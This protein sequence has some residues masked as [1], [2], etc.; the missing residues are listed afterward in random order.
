MRKIILSLAALALLGACAAT[1]VLPRKDAGVATHQAALTTDP[2]QAALW[3]EAADSGALAGI[4]KLRAGR[5]QLAPRQAARVSDRPAAMARTPYP[6]ALQTAVSISLPAGFGGRFTGAV[7][8]RAVE[9]EFMELVL[10]DKQVLRLHSKLDGVPLRARA[11][12]TADVVLR[13]G[14]IY[15]R[16]DI[17]AVR[18][19]GDELIHALVGAKGP[20]R[21]A[22]RERGLTAEQTGK[23]E[24]NA[25]AVRVSLGG[26]TR[27]L[28]P[29]EQADFGEAGLTLKILAS[30]AVQGQATHALEGEPYRIELLAWRTRPR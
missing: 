12:E 18:L 25:M 20:V 24:G 27:T 11:N 7:P 21:F 26:E 19:A 29:G 10:A 13:A 23:P 1:D 3:K 4:A 17:L 6:Q 8:V 9:G 22:L 16:N 30:V 15:E 28:G 5:A 2:A 14:D